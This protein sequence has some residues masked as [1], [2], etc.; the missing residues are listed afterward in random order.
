MAAR[1]GLE[2]LAP[3]IKITRLRSVAGQP[4]V[5]VSSYLPYAVCPGLIRADLRSQSLYAYLEEEYGLRIAAGRRQIEAV[6]ATKEEAELLAI[7]PGAPLILI[8]STSYLEDGTA[9][10]YY[11]A[12]HRSDRARFEVNL[13]RV[14]D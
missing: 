11:H 13:M 10:E 2:E 4:V 5:L 6:L 14:H 12:L 1:L 7:S 8:D 9:L 3:V